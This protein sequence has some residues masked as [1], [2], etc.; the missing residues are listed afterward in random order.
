MMTWLSKNYILCC[1]DVNIVVTKTYALACSH[2]VV[3]V[4]DIHTCCHRDGGRRE[5]A[6]MLS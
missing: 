5:N 1:H 3:V 6:H 2:G 4:T